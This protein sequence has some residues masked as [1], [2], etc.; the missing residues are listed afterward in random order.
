MR[1]HMTEVQALI[2]IFQLGFIIGI[3][4]VSVTRG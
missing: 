1:L 4:L 3:L 2:I